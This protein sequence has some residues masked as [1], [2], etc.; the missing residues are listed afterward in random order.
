MTDIPALRDCGLPCLIFS[1][2]A[3]LCDFRGPVGDVP[4]LSTPG[5]L[6]HMFLKRLG[7]SREGFLRFCASP[8]RGPDYRIYRLTPPGELRCAFAERAVLLSTAVTAVFLASSPT[9]FHRLMSPSSCYAADAVNRIL[10]ELMFLTDGGSPAF[11]SLSPELFDVVRRIPR[12]AEAL[13]ARRCS[14]RCCDLTKVLSAV[15]SAVEDMPAFGNCRIRLSEEHPVPREDPAFSELPVE[16]FVSVLTA[17]LS[18]A[19]N[20]TADGELDLI[21]KDHGAVRETAVR[22]RSDRMPQTRGEEGADALYTLPADFHGR[23]RYLTALCALTSMD[24]AVSCPDHSGPEVRDPGDNGAVRSVSL[25]LLVGCEPPPVLDFKYDEPE[26]C[27]SAVVS[28]TAALFADG[29]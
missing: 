11:S 23:I 24:L 17:L 14:V 8:G 3:A 18:L 5:E 7:R 1:E 10:F 22:F 2:D 28:E 20:L 4:E 29:S 27:A 15:V 25:S 6:R 26:R 9:A 21:L 13:F 19:A 16:A 12:L